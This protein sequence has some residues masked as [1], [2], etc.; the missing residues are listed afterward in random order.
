MFYL[1]VGVTWFRLLGILSG[2]EGV[3]RARSCTMSSIYHM[4]ISTSRCSLAFLMIWAVMPPNNLL[5]LLLLRFL[6]YCS[7]VRQRRRYTII[8]VFALH[9]R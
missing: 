1:S 3:E 9:E 8:A 5:L 7:V 2:V 4:A 6:H